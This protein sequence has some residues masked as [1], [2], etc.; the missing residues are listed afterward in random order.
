MYWDGIKIQIIVSGSITTKEFNLLPPFS[1]IG[2]KNTEFWLTCTLLGGG[3]KYQNIIDHASNLKAMRLIAR[4][5]SNMS[6]RSHFFFS[7]LH[8]E[9]H[10]G[11]YNMFIFLVTDTWKDQNMVLLPKC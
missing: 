5:P 9:L 4:Q 1:Q 3:R 11:S 2:E 10:L 6:P 8:I 7:F